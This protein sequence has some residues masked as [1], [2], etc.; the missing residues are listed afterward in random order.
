MLKNLFVLTIT[1]LLTS[2]TAFAADN[3]HGNDSKDASL[4]R[5]LQADAPGPGNSVE[6][7]GL[8]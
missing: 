2:L 6:P 1:F 4:Y 8:Q 3:Q 7:Q 5:G